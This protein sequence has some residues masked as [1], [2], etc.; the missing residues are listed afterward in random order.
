VQLTLGIFANRGSEEE[1]FI[2]PEDNSRARRHLQQ[3]D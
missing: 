2:L 3:L 1:T